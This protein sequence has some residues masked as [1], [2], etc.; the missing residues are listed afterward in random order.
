MT[1]KEISVA[2][3]LGLVDTKN[4]EKNR[5]RINEKN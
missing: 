5:T 1:P 4:P 2:N 3:R